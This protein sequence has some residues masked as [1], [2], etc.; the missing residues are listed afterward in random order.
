M[1][2]INSEISKL[3]IQVKNSCKK[4]AVPA[5]KKMIPKG[6][7]K[8]VA[9]PTTAAPK[10]PVAPKNTCAELPKLKTQIKQL[11][12]QRTVVAKQMAAL[13]KQG[14]PKTKEA[15]LAR[16]KVS[17][18]VNTLRDQLV[19]HLRNARVAQLSCTKK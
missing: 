6:A 18:Q 4:K 5:K 2:E 14:P 19:V 1:R 11:Y 8:P 12:D 3:L 7:P 10:A 16:D 17:Q 15:S 9:K 13:M